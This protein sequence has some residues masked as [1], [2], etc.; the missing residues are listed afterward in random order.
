MFRTFQVCKQEKKKVSSNFWPADGS[1][2]SNYGV[3]GLKKRNYRNN[4]R[5]QKKLISQV[6]NTKENITV[7]AVEKKW[8]TVYHT[9]VFLTAVKINLSLPL[10]TSYWH[11]V[12]PRNNWLFFFLFCFLSNINKPQ[13]VE[14]HNS[15]QKKN[16]KKTSHGGNVSNLFLRLAAGNM[17]SSSFQ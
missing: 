9:K 11:R 1:I 15:D 12:M 10:S 8:P 5:K 3:A 6:L 4:G 2:S 17:S 16:K 14:M 7:S 13:N